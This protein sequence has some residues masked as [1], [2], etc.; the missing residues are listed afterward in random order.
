MNESDSTRHNATAR[1]FET[2]LPVWQKLGQRLSQLESRGPVT[3]VTL[4]QT[5]RSYPELARDLAVARRQAPNGRLTRYLA[6]TYL[7]FHRVIFRSPLA[8]REDLKTLF[9][10]DIPRLVYQLKWHI[11]NVSLF[12]IV[13]MGAGWWL[14]GT[15][16]ELAS[17]FASEEMIENV[18]QG[19]LWTDGLLNIMPSSLLS[20]QI[21][22]NNIVVSLFAVSLGALYGLGTIYIIG[23]NGLML[24]GVFA[25]TNHHGLAGRLFEFV[26]AHGF[27]ELSVI[28]ICGAVGLSIGEAIARP[29]L[30]SRRAAFQRAMS[31]GGR[32]VL[33]CVIFLIGAGLIEGYVS[34]DP[35]YSMGARLGIGLSYFAVFLWA[36]VGFPP[37]SRHRRPALSHAPLGLK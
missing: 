27:V 14:V 26:C 10:V 15:Y 19:I 20:V 11:L 5:M 34:P 22:T 31:R 12:F 37:V 6:A 4:R 32:I 23:M 16:P 36:L 24:G 8:L 18:R 1:W 9:L 2:R 33:L 7:R 28:C 17:L 21:F 29:G 25:F 35:S 3:P 30:L 13:C